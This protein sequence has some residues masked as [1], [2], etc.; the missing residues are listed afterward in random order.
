MTAQLFQTEL[1]NLIQ[2]S[3][4]KNSDVKHAAEQSL[5][6]L[7][8]L[9]LTSEAQLT[10]D[11]LRKPHFGKPFILACKTRHQKLITIGVTCIQRLVA[12][13][14]L[15]HDKLRDVLD[16]LSQTA[17]LGLDAQLRVLQTLPSLFQYYSD[18]LNG[19]LLAATFEL[20]SSLQSSKTAAVSN[21][22]SATIQQLVVSVFEK[23]ARFDGTGRKSSVKNITINGQKATVT[24]VSYDGLRI[25]QDFCNFLEDGETEFVNVKTLPKPF[26]L[27]L[28]TS[29]LTD[30]AQL[31]VHHPEQAQVLE[32]RLMPLAIKF[33]S[34]WNSFP[35]MIRAARLLSLLLKD[36]M[37]VFPDHCESALDLLIRQLDPDHAVPWKRVVSMEIFRNLYS[38]P[39][40]VRQMFYLFDEQEGHRNIM[41]DHMACM[42]RLASEKPSVIGVGHQSTLPTGPVSARDAMDETVT[43][44][45][46]VA[47][48][49]GSGTGQMSACGVSTQFSLVRSPF[50]DMLDKQDAPPFP[51]TY[52]Y[53]LVLNCIGAF[54]DSLAKFILPMTIPDM[55][56]KKRLKEKQCGGY[57]ESNEAQKAYENARVPLNPLDLESHPQIQEI[58][59]CA[60]IIEECWPAVLATCSTFLHAALD[61]EFYHNL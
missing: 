3:K 50:L 56:N 41:R 58:H 16:G 60:F 45:T 38:K 34:D 8:A 59:T 15:P 46:G 24:S 37:S 11:L 19:D 36:Y 55:K 33:V 30:N 21:T 48:V 7:R 35:I 18:D 31:I 40:L 49:I 20:C 39:K 61:N 27:E 28:L 26:V 22:A 54:A 2:E 29:I 6:E 53:S 25:L 57:D 12:I 51:E 1:A 5:T 44:E 52:I 4:R 43:L 14:A 9:P 47:G 23:I 10:A 13:H 32:S 42:V 17:T